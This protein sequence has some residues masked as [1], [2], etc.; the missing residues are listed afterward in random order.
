[1]TRQNRTF[2]PNGSHFDPSGG[3]ILTNNKFGLKDD[4]FSSVE[5]ARQA[6]ANAQRNEI[7]AVQGT[8]GA[9][10]LSG[11]QWQ[12]GRDGKLK[13]YMRNGL[14]GEGRQGWGMPF[15]LP[16]YYLGD[17]DI[18][19]QEQ[20]PENPGP[21]TFQTSTWGTNI[22]ISLGWVRVATVVLEAKPIVP[23]IEGEYDY[24]IEYKIPIYAFNPD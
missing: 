18:A 16:G 5:A 6:V 13:T 23:T 8:R 7:N 2:G 4:S 24:Y 9:G 1:M 17:V 14:G 15:E 10:G 11:R 21:R 22:P 3:R 20:R 12:I 19:E